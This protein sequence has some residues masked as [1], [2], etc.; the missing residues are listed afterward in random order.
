M[1]YFPHFVEYSIYFLVCDS[2]AM[3]GSNNQPVLLYLIRLG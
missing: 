1:Y 2:K 3:V